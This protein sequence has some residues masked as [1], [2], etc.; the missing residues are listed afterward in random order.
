MRQQR[1]EA[2]QVRASA[3]LG[4]AAQASAPSGAGSNATAAA[5]D[6]GPPATTALELGPAAYHRAG[7]QLQARAYDPRHLLFPPQAVLAQGGGAASGRNPFGRLLEARLAP[8]AF[9]ARVALPFGTGHFL[10]GTAPGLT[11]E[12]AGGRHTA[13]VVLASERDYELL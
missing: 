7:A 9:S 1:V 10:L 2:G 6:P 4:G 11:E 13:V 5:T 3:D 8:E 12:A